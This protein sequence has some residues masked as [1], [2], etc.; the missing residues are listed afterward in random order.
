MLWVIIYLDR[1][2]KYSIIFWTNFKGINKLKKDI[3]KQ[4]IRKKFCAAVISNCALSFNKFRLNFIDKLSEYKTVDMGGNCRNNIKRTVKNKIEYL[5]NYKFSISMENSDGDGY[6]SEKIVDSFLAGTIPIYFG[7]YL[8][9]EYFNPKS[10]ILIRGEKDIEKKIEYIQKIDQDDNLYKE[11]IKEK[12]I[13]DDNFANK[14]DDIEIKSFLRHIFRQNKNKAYR[15]DDYYNNFVDNFSFLFCNL[16]F[17][18]LL[19]LL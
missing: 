12:P 2:F 7:D 15:R 4:P 14:I 5:S 16:K 17:L 8:L 1:Y 3:L 11:I 18:F 9:D 19:I 6:L 10:Y 13:F